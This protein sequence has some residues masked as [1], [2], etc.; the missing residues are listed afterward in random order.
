MTMETEF[1]DG[2]TDEIIKSCV[3]DVKNIWEKYNSPILEQKTTTSVSGMRPYSEPLEPDQQEVVDMFNGYVDQ[4]YSLI[5][6]FHIGSGIWYT[7][8]GNTDTWDN[9]ATEAREIIT[10]FINEQLWDAVCN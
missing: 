9:F 2:L 1:K 3:E 8:I 7:H 10:T 6:I 5:D 4:L